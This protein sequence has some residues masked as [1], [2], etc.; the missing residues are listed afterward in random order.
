MFFLSYK[1]LGISTVI[2][3]LGAG[4]SRLPA[5]LMDVEPQ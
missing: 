1:Q 5:P 4:G 2:L 3:G